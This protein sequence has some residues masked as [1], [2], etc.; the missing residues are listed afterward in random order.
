MLLNS[1]A[2]IEKRKDYEIERKREDHSLIFLS[3]K[4]VSKGEI[5][6]FTEEDISIAQ[7][8]SK[9][10]FQASR[11]S[12]SNWVLPLNDSQMLPIHASQRLDQHAEGPGGGARDIRK[13]RLSNVEISDVGEEEMRSCYVAQDV[14]E[15]LA[16]SDPSA[17]AS[18]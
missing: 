7:C 8:Y 17:L 3:R 18:Q 6:A 4:G 1:N 11:S 10:G 14:L 9:S 15:L 13:R 16:S 5:S 12:I 2:R